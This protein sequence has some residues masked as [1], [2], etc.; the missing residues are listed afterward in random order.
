PHAEVAA[1]ICR[2]AAPGG[3]AVQERGHRRSGIRPEE[4]SVPAAEGLQLD[5]NDVPGFFAPGLRANRYA[6]QR[7]LRIAEA[8]RR[9]GAAGKPTSLIIAPPAIEPHRTPP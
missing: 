2:L 7:P 9:I 8:P 1:P 3:Q 4:A 6:N 5:I